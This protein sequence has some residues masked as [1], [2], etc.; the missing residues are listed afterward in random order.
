[1]TQEDLYRLVVEIANATK[2]TGDLE[3]LEGA[4]QKLRR[5]LQAVALDMDVLNA[6][7]LNDLIG[8]KQYREEGERL[9][10][11]EQKLLQ[12]M[13]DLTRVRRD[14]I[15]ATTAAAKAED[16]LAEKK[17]KTG[18]ATNKLGLIAIEAGRGL[19]DL[20]Y[21]VSGAMN[22]LARMGEIIGGPAGVTVAITAVT[23][24][25]SQLARH[26]PELMN[27]FKDH[28]I[29]NLKKD[30]ESLEGHLKRLTD[31][32]YK[33]EADYAQIEQVTKE[34]EKLK[35]ATADFEAL[36]NAQTTTQQRIGA[37]VTEAVVEFGG[38]T[39]EA[40]G[41]EN[42]AKVIR[43]IKEREGTLYEGSE[44]NVRAR[45][46]AKADI[47]KLQE[48]IDRDAK[49]SESG[50]EAAGIRLLESLP[51]MEEL[52]SA[53]DT[54]EKTL[55]TVVEQHTNGLVAAASKGVEAARKQLEGMFMANRGDF[56][57]A[58]IGAQ[59]G[60]GLIASSAENVRGRADEA[61]L[62][63]RQQ[64]MARLNETL[65]AKA[66]KVAKDEAKLTDDLNKAG[67][68]NQLAGAAERDAEAAKAMTAAQREEAARNRANRAEAARAFNAQASA[69]EGSGPVIPG[70]EAALLQNQ[71]A[72]QSGDRRALSDSAMAERLAAQLAAEMQRSGM[73]RD[74]LHAFAVASKVVGEAQ[75]K[76]QGQ[77]MQNLG[78]ATSIQEA[79]AMT[80]MGFQQQLMTLGNRQQRIFMM[81]QGM[82]RQGPRMRP[83]G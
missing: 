63:R 72:R 49:L 38:G 33:F 16:D 7:F 83:Q 75:Q 9:T 48:K 1:M 42:I 25:I 44:G 60:A 62:L 19:E 73:D 2:A 65:D 15:A 12:A 3:Q 10:A 23:V 78:M 30:M 79:Q 50:D 39:D 40:S 71:M 18:K 24:L 77:V 14:S 13:T 37:G 67:Q 55:R 17:E 70:I 20:Q 64:Q 58:G 61:N 22:N 52:K 81:F 68:E 45:D 5:A 82:Q 28:T 31:K 32:K 21:G 47:A 4:N 11:V 29:D 36:K 27:A 35:K 26:W 53:L 46:K 76:M 57:A 43:G 54:E 59:F 66:E 41:A 34:I 6:S 51:R 74:P 56:A 80:M 8:E 69:L